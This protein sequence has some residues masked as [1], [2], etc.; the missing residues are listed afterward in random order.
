L[1]ANKEQLNEWKLNFLGKIFLASVGAWLFG[2]LTNVKVRGTKEQVDAV[3]NAMLASRK[4][5]D[6]LNRP[7]ASVE[8]VIQKLDLKNAS[9]REFE[10]RLGVKWPL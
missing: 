8:S 4:F 1:S 2:K 7:G 3:A 10:A 6:E 9:A 5:Q